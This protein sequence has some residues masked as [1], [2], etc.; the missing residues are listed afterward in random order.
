MIL[1]LTLIF[2]LQGFGYY[3]LL[4]TAD[5]C[6]TIIIDRSITKPGPYCITHLILCGISYHNIRIILIKSTLSQHL[7]LYHQGQR[8]LQTRAKQEALQRGGGEVRAIL[9]LGEKN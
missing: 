2:D 9:F 3:V 7:N 1:I 4:C 6:A 8:R 5:M